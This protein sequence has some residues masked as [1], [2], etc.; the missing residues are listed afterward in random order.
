M[1]P[2]SLCIFLLLVLSAPA[3]GQGGSSVVSGPME[4]SPDLPVADRMHCENVRLDAA[5]AALNDIYRELLD[6]L[7]ERGRERLVEAQRAW[8]AFRDRDFEL[9]AAVRASG[10]AAQS[11]EGLLEQVRFLRA[12]TEERTVELG[13][14]AEAAR[15]MASVAAS[16][17]APS[18]AEA[19]PLPRDYPQAVPVRASSD[20][21]LALVLGPHALRLHWLGETATGRVTG[22]MRG[23][24]L[25]LS[26]AQET[27][28]GFVRLDGWVEAVTDNAFVLNG[29]VSS[30]VRGLGDGKPCV[31]TGRMEFRRHHG[32]P[33]WRLQ[34]HTNP[35][36]G[37][38]DYVDVF[39]SGSPGGGPTR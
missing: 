38:T 14:M 8:L 21:A 36:T 10:N 24:V 4:C 17:P 33:F 22:E 29:Q 12:L 13:A 39:V 27:P 9:R 1:R 2:A 30:R 16:S 37:I 11:Q 6:L 18:R 26:G 35:C 28:E 7:D 5:D 31:R 34:S 25:V 3:F 15:R 32:R 19:P 23:K 20:Q